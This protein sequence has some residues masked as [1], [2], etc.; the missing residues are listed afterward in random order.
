VRGSDLDI[1]AT[2]FAGVFRSVD[3][4]S[5]WSEIAGDLRWNLV[6]VAAHPVDPDRLVLSGSL[7]ISVPGA[8]PGAWVSRNSGIIAT[9]IRKFTAE[10]TTDRALRLE[11]T[12]LPARYYLPKEDVR[13]DLLQPTSFHTTC[14][15]KGEASYWSAEIGGQRHDGIVWAYESPIPTV[16][17]LAGHVSFYPDRAQVSVDGKTWSQPLGGASSSTLTILSFAPTRAKLVRIVRNAPPAQPAQNWAIQTLRLYEVRAPT[18][19]TR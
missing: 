9:S 11:E 19:P 16:A 3:G 4:G 17:E 2:T 1:V 15:F 13:M 7:G 18:A 6:R 5:Q 10:A 8:T 14:P 12:G